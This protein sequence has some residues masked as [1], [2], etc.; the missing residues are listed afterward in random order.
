MMM[1]SSVPSPD[2]VTAAVEMTV[3][4]SPVTVDPV[5]NVRQVADVG[6]HRCGESRRAVVLNDEECVR[7]IRHIEVAVGRRL[8]VDRGG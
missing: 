7:V 8:L 4:D 5:V 3:E 1:T 6:D 2:A